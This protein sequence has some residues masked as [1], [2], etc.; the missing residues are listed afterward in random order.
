MVSPLATAKA[1]RTP[2]A[3][4]SRSPKATAD[5]RRTQYRLS[6]GNY[7]IVELDNVPPGAPVY[8]ICYSPNFARGTLNG[9]EVDLHFDNVTI[10]GSYRDACVTV[11]LVVDSFLC[12]SGETE[13]R[14]APDD[15]IRIADGAV[16]VLDM[17][18]RSSPPLDIGLTTYYNTVPS[19]IE[20]LVKDGYY[21]HHID[22]LLVKGRPFQYCSR[23][24]NAVR[25]LPKRVRVECEA[26]SPTE[27]G[28]FVR[29]KNP[30]R[31]EVG[32]WT[33]VMLAAYIVLALILWV[34]YWFCAI[35]EKPEP[36]S[37][38]E[39]TAEALTES[40]IDP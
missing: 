1:S 21:D 37:G 39:T 26:V 25:G 14:P 11:R 13:L 38:D 40:L 12:V 2:A 17:V 32:K 23:W 3:T 7:G 6:N 16:V 10:Y 28:L 35:R 18:Y 22:D 20:L 30:F 19:A 31:M 8:L 29:A 5:P 4:R 9:T 36:P 24:A 27:V 15:T 34:I 33:G